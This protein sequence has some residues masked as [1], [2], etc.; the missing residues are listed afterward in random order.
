MTNKISKKIQP[1]LTPD[2]ARTL[3]LL[4]RGGKIN[5]L[6]DGWIIRVGDT[7][8]ATGGK[9][10]LD[11]LTER[12]FLLQHKLTEAGYKMLETHYTQF[13]STRL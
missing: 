7:T 12:G 4:K 9:K 3:G 11:E 13:P 6:A 10:T 1:A 2:E 5:E 8:Y